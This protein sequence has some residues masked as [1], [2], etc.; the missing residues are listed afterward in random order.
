[1]Q[2]TVSIGHNRRTYPPIQT[3]YGGSRY[4]VPV[5][6]S[7]SSRANASSESVRTFVNRLSKL[8]QLLDM[9]LHSSHFVEHVTAQEL[10]LPTAA[11]GIE[12]Q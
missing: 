12:T 8:P 6:S 1:M 10:P 11:K 2:S 4:M 9:Q 5:A 7:Y 3:R